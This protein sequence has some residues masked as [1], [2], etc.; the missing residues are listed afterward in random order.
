MATKK[1]RKSSSVSE[2]LFTEGHKFSF[3]QATRLLQGV[4]GQYSPAKNKNPVGHD[5]TVNR[6]AVRFSV[7]PSLSF[8]SNEIVKID[9]AEPDIDPVADA[10]QTMADMQVAFMGLSG[11]SGVLPA[12]IT[13]VE[14]LR[15]REKDTALKDFLDLFDNRSISLFYRA[16]EKYRLPISYERHALYQQGDDP[17]TQA[18]GA[19]LGF[20]SKR[21]KNDA[22]FNQEEL[23]YYAGFFSGPRRSASALQS[24]LTEYLGVPVVVNQFIGEWLPLLED[25][26]TQLPF[27][28]RK[29]KNNCLGVDMVIGERCFTVEGKFELEIGPLSEQ[30]Y[31]EFK[32]GSAKQKS[33]LRYTQL[34]VGKNFDFDL[35]Y[36]LQPGAISSW[37]LS[38]PN[39]SLFNL[40]WNTWLASDKQHEAGEFVTVCCHEN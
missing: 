29:G 9:L 17:F 20:D 37:Y 32:P 33:L 30:E 8:Q 16:W 35:K 11:S 4:V 34:F 18:L 23:I 5:L 2:K 21:F 39:P 28:P 19:I 1:R 14:L 25:D 26:R 22:D 38:E 24:S 10:N 15:Q 3:F 7:P 12:Y 27:F 40:G 13:E 6:E 36:K 31:Q